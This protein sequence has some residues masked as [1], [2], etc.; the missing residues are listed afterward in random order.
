MKVASLFSVYI[1]ANCGC[2]CVCALI[3]FYRCALEFNWAIW[4]VYIL[5]Y[6]ELSISMPISLIHK[7]FFCAPQIFIVYAGCSCCTYEILAMKF[8]CS[9]E[10]RFIAVCFC[11]FI[12]YI[13]VYFWFTETRFF[14]SAVSR[15]NLYLVSFEIACGFNFFKMFYQIL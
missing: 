13:A 12:H 9:R 1:D 3:I 6:Y 8:L 15:W 2:E 14:S 4:L 10:L 11:F 5:F 7:F